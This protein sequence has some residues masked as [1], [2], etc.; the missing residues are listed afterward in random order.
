MYLLRDAIPSPWRDEMRY[1]KLLEFCAF[2]L[3]TRADEGE[4]ASMHIKTDGYIEKAWTRV[5]DAIHREEDF[6]I[7]EYM[8]RLVDSEFDTPS[9]KFLN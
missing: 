1:S 7:R 5:L 2:I 3:A 6:E 4:M 8:Q 9:K